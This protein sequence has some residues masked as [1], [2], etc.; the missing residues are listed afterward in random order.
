MK[1]EEKRKFFLE[2]LEKSYQKLAKYEKFIGPAIKRKIETILFRPNGFYFLYSFLKFSLFFST[3]NKKTKLLNYKEIIL[4]INDL[5][6]LFL[7][8]HGFLYALSEYKLTKFFIKNLKETDIFYDIGASYGFY[9]YLAS[10]FCQEIHSFE[11]IP[12]VFKNL[13][14]NLKDSPN[15]FL[16]NRA[17]SNKAG[18]VPF[19][20]IAGSSG[21]STMLEIEGEPKRRNNKIEVNAIT[22]DDYIKNHSFKPTII[23]L[24]VEGVETRVIGGG[25]EFFKNN[26]PLISMEIWKKAGGGEISRKAVEKLRHLGYKSYYLNLDGEIEKI[27]GDLTERVAQD[28][29]PFDN[30]IFLKN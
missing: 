12:H 8:K 18:L 16:N 9:T 4:D 23:K 2:E 3:K 1:L 24:D 25:K 5:D 14:R 22:L 11:P 10:E 30:Y 19:Y 29:L 6:S 21:S 15:V 28:D 27:E 26:S 13:V 17:I 20:V 7:F